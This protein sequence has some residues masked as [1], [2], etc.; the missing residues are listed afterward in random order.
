MTQIGRLLA[1]FIVVTVFS[2]TALYVLPVW[3]NAAVLGLLIAFVVVAGV[4]K[5]VLITLTP[6]RR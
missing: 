1:S 5:L 3:F 6:P 2:W 4:I